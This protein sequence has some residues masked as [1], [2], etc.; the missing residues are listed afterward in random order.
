MGAD[1]HI[2]IWADSAVR[3]RFGHKTD[4][5]FY[6]LPTYYCHELGGVKYHHCYWGDNIC[7]D[8][9]DIGDSYVDI[10][11]KVTAV[12]LGKFIDWLKQNSTSWEVWT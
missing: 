2:E 3:E 12:E 10:Q 6:C 4:D 8:F 1:G 7:L 11:K 9:E 5:L